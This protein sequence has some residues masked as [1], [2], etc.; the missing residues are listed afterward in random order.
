M[1]Y[2]TSKV[3]ITDG[4][5]ATTNDAKHAFVRFSALNSISSVSSAV[6]RLHTA[7]ASSSGVTVRSAAGGWTETALNYGNAQAPGAAIGTIGSFSSN[8]WVTLDVTSYVKGGGT[9]FAV[10]PRDTSSESFSSREAGAAVAPQLIL[11]YVSSVPVPIIT[12]R[13]TSPATSTP[14]PSGTPG[15]TA[16][17]N[18]S[19]TPGSIT[20]GP[21]R[22]AFY[23]PWFPQTWGS[24]TNFPFTNY[25]PS[26]GTYSSDDTAIIAKHI[27]AMRYAHLNSAI[28]SWWGQSQQSEQTRFPEQLSAASGTGLKWGLYYEKEGFSDPSVNEITGDLNYIKSRYATSSNYLKIDSKPVVLVYGD[29]NDG[30]AMADRWKQA[31]AAA[32]N[33]FYIVLKVF[34]GYAACASQPNSWHQYSPAVAVASQPGYSYEI[35]PGFWK[36]GEPVRLAR[37]LARWNSDVQSMVTS[38]APLQL[39]TTFSEWGEGTAVESAQEWAT[40]S[41]YGAYLDALHNFVPDSTIG[42]PSPTPIPAPTS[43]PIPPIGSGDAV[44][45]AAG[46]IACDPISASYNAGIGTATECQEKATS[47][48]IASLS[49]DAV[50]TLGDNQYESGTLSNFNASFGSTW[51]RMKAIIHPG[52]GNHE[53]GEGGSNAGYFDYFNGIGVASGHAGDRSKGYYSYNVGQWH[54]IAVNSNCGTYS[55]NG[56]A[57]GCQAGSAQETWLKADL[58]ANNN[59]CTLAYWH[60]P[61]FSSG[62]SHYNDAALDNTY[63][64]LWNDL[65][66]GGVDVVLN[67]HDHDYER[68]AP[69]R[70]DGQLDTAFGIR[71][72]IVGTGGKNHYSFQAPVNGSEV[73]ASPFGV[74]KMN[75]R[76]SSFDWNFIPVAGETFTDHGTSA[77]HGKPGSI[78]PPD[79]IPPSMPTALKT[80]SVGTNSVALA[81]NAATDNVGVSMYQVMR[82]GRIIGTVTAPNT[83]FTD[84]TVLPA[85]TYSYTVS[86]LDPSGNMSGSSIAI[87]V[88]T[89]SLA[90][91]DTTPPS[92]VTVAG[93]VLSS[94]QI[95]LSWNAATDNVGV[96][97]YQV[98]RGG[99]QVATVTSL[100]YGDGSLTANTT[101]SYAVKAFDPSG[102]VAAASNTVT[103]STGTV[104]T[105]TPTPPPISAGGPCG[106]TASA[107]AT[108]Q[109]V[110]VVLMENH[111]IGDV[112]GNSAA[113]YMTGL[114]KQ[115]GYATNY[116]S[117]GGPSLPNY[118]GLTSGSN[119]GITDDAA[120]SAHN[121]T[122]DN[123]FRQ[124]LT[125]GQTEKSYQES[126][127]GNCALTSAGSY[128]VK[129]N[130]EAYYNGGSDRSACLA[131]NIPLGTTGSGAFLTA[132]NSNTLANFSFVTPNLCNDTHD[133]STATGDAW[134]AS[135][136]P[137]IL[138]SSGYKSGNTAVILVYDEY[139]N[140]PNIMI[141]PSVSPGTV[142]GV[143]FNHFSLLRTM[144][145][146]LGIS[147]HLGGAASANSMRS[148]FN[149]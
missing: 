38:N 50:L 69:L 4:S 111:R 12:P 99:V 67:G 51:G 93:K 149:F 135:W 7:T 108:Y 17:P 118:L 70:P 115:C 105:P 6:L 41:G 3:L 107:P 97:G 32:G 47:N 56:S 90:T 148:A 31:D 60:V 77:C 112:I 18:P 53:G 137:I 58:A 16:L 132:I 141:A 48:L 140:M 21:V 26:L 104:I 42:G 120:P 30:C 84:V 22:A 74:L 24:G 121:L 13:P 73:R 1:N 128:A 25:H 5:T 29:A 44:I 72:F 110:I 81:W 133:C 122:V 19:P 43:T 101:Y 8:S 33:S 40:S 14:L 126:M 92:I 95:N 109:H 39:V 102:N 65:Y 113:P 80:T 116:S 20:M 82:A 100:S 129:H 130:P 62:S 78:L 131:N 88:L 136:M 64:A 96:S 23:Y 119:Q 87:S 61:R 86:A 35:A 94:D 139:T 37:D 134:V 71:E 138:A 114:A 142:S 89:Q 145:E 36:K 52:I 117:V 34:P 127:G 103:L 46:D 147:A 15:P 45:V 11:N 83:S 125:S 28:S 144:E 91:P 68:F 75:L 66:A 54:I 143:A 27:A 49:P 124:V 106:R 2:G 63:T 76:A 146:M 9:N 10:W 98:F 57:T 59:A 123:I 85:S 55:F 79:T